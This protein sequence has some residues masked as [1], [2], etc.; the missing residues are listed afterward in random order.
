MADDFY[1]QIRDISPDFNPCMIFDVGANKGQSVNDML[2]VFPGA[3]INAFE[4]GSATFEILR[5]RFG[6]HANVAVHRLA[7]DSRNGVVAFSSQAA[8]T[9]NHIL[10]AEPGG[11][12]AVTDLQAE[13]V[14]ARMGDDFC[15]ERQ[16]DRIDFLK[17]DT[18]GN[19]LAVLA[20]FADLLRHRKI[21]YL[22][23]EC[24]TT[25]DNRYHVHLERFIHFLHPFGY[26]LFSLN[27]M[28]RKVNKTRQRLNGIW[29]CNAVFVAEVENPLL[30]RDG[31]N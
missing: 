20:G 24:T 29:F 10:R 18:E 5:D 27:D 17:V 6:D 22:Q 23:V 9:G 11:E 31:N 7:L 14:E 26:R 25:L 15:R 19:D 13:T 16:I 12:G 4:P 21:T 8:A 30:R 28:V 2:A 1:R 3:R